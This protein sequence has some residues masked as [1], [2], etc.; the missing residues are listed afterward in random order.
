MKLPCKCGEPKY[1]GK[2]YCSK[3]LNKRNLINYRSDKAVQKRKELKELLDAKKLE[4][5]N[6]T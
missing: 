5:K 1:Q 3:C 2:P 6:N 4:L